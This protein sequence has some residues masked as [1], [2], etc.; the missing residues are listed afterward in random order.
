MDPQTSGIESNS[1]RVRQ[2]L[3]GGGRKA[4]KSSAR[5]RPYRQG[6]GILD[7]C[8]DG[9]WQNFEKWTRQLDPVD[10]ERSI[11]RLI[12]DPSM[13]SS[14]CMSTSFLEDSPSSVFFNCFELLFMAVCMFVP[15]LRLCSSLQAQA[16]RAR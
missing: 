12:C 16:W 4:K 9:P 15:G 7:V 3:L 13:T 2:F 14:H 6:I 1:R 5:S 11:S 8:R 10:E